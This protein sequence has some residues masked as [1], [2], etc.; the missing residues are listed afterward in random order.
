MDSSSADTS[1]PTPP[2]SF[3]SHSKSAGFVNPATDV[4]EN[5]PPQHHL[6]H[7]FT[8]TAQNQLSNDRPII[9][10]FAEANGDNPL[11]VGFAADHALAPETWRGTAIS[12]WPPFQSSIYLAMYQ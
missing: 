8:K 4:P 3:S 1:H 7:S 10:M 6:Q 2:L 11:D 5:G 12:I 9:Q